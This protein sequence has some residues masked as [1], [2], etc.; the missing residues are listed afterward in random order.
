M[1]DTVLNDFY[2]LFHL[3]FP[4][5]YELYTIIS[6]LQIRKARLFSRPY[7]GRAAI[8]MQ[9]CLCQSPYSFQDLKLLL[10]YIIEVRAEES[11]LG[12][13]KP[14]MMGHSAFAF[15]LLQLRLDVLVIV[16]YIT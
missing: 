15:T 9:V 2:V 6:T 1:A 4:K 5:L 7:S 11:G 13:L 14:E 3:L 10:G 16:I 12:I 8:W